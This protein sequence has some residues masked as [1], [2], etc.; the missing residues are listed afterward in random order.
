MYTVDFC[1]LN[2]V[3]QKKVKDLA[4]VAKSKPIQHLAM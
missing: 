3:C 2:T 1:K 4:T